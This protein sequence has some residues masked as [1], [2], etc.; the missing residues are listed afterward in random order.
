[1]KTLYNG[2]PADSEKRHVDKRRRTMR[3][4]D[5]ASELFWQLFAVA[6]VLDAVCSWR[7][8]SCKKK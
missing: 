3:A 6:I 2:R 7:V 1:M 4:I 5:F 8:G